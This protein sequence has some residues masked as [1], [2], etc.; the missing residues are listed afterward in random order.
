MTEIA[1]GS[2]RSRPSRMDSLR[3]HLRILHVLASVDFKLKY[4]GSALGY[5]W[6]VLKPLTLFLVLY[7]VFGRVFHLGTISHYYP[8]ALLI[9]IVLFTFFGDG[10]TMGMT[11]IVARESLVRKM[12][13]PRLII[14]TSATLTATITLAI[15][16]TVIIVFLAWN[17][18]VPRVD[19]FLVLIL[20]VEL[21]IFVLGVSLILTT[22][23]VRF[24]DIGQVWEL[25]LQ[26]LFYASPI[27]YPVGYL[28][29]W[30]RRIAFLNPFT[31]VMQD[32]RAL[33]L[34]PDIR[35]NK[36]TAADAFGTSLGRLIP[37]GIAFGVLALG[38]YLF[39]RDE[40]WFAER[41]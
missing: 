23:F 19:W 4:A 24:R 37:I 10:C 33:I 28:P 26:L 5:V 29:E 34:Y 36:I 40:P 41:V 9:G 35:P 13:F 16:L 18:I 20:L 27:I 6:S 12:S 11:S 14:P 25:V 17:R 7:L 1:A 38:L 31:Q 30:A 22:L 21:Y 15:N 2:G 8:L 32:I 39:K 3:H